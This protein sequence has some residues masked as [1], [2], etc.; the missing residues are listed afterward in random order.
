MRF[1]VESWSPDYGSPVDEES[2]AAGAAEVDASV[3][4]PVDE[5]AP[6]RP[7][8]G[9]EPLTEV[10]FVDGVRRVEAHVWIT[11]DDGSVHQGIC[12]SYAAGAVRC[13]GSADLLSPRVERG[14]FSPVPA[15]RPIRTRHATFGLHVPDADG[16]DDLALLLQRRMGELESRVARLA[17][18]GQLVIV[19]GPLRAGQGEGPP[20]APFD[21]AA[22]PPGPFGTPAN[23]VERP[24][25]GA[26]ATSPGFVG[27]VKTHR[28]S[29]GPPVVRAT[30]TRLGVGERTPL[31]HLDTIRPRYTWY[32][33]LPCPVRHG[34]AGIVRLEVP[35]GCGVAAA[36][37]VADRLA[38][39]LGRFAS[40]EAKDPRAPQNLYPVGGL[41]REL[42]RRLGDPALLFR[43][44]R[45]AAG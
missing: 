12:A 18:S 39:S 45:E 2:L 42:R 15:A 44:L 16:S 22:G 38:V 28:R 25:D 36:A 7:P 21:T 24:A 20:A 10:V 23:P 1:A 37:G 19:D 34:W 31:L 6:V 3:E 41:E 13:N 17:G 9:T 27:Y 32:Q 8:A 30:V 33:R 35:A 14:L 4:V 40:A 5:W 29:Y 11:A 43:A 26:E